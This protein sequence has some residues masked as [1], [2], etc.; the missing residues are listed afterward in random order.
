MLLLVQVR[1]LRSAINYKYIKMKI[2]KPIAM[3]F[4]SVIFSA[5]F[6]G[7]ALSACPSMVD[8]PNELRS[9][10]RAII[11]DFF[12][13]PLSSSYTTNEILDLL[14]FY[15]NEKSSVLIDTCDNT[16]TKTNTPITTILEKTIDFQEECTTPGETRSCGKSDVGEC[17]FGTQ[18]CQSNN[19][20]GNCI[21]EIAPSVEICDGKDN[22]CDGTIDENCGLLISAS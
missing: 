2:N 10:L 3:I 5:L 15:K 8:T 13:D 18:S 12:S 16:G 7:F 19:Q 1:A 6:A 4:I 11:L 22:N 20:W 17:S 21:G 14:D 9:E